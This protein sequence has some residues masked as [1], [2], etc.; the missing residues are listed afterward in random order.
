MPSC[1]LC[2]A[3]KKT[4]F[5]LVKSIKYLTHLLSGSFLPSFSLL[6]SPSFIMKFSTIFAVLATVA[7]A[8]T[9]MLNGAVD[10]RHLTN[11]E[12]LARRQ[13]PNSP[14]HLWEPTKSS[15]MWIFYSR[16]SAVL[17]IVFRSGSPQGKPSGSPNKSQSCN[18]GSVQCCEILATR[19]YRKNLC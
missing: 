18:T 1:G 2:K 15:G 19:S 17:I 10:A 5:T 16:I 13:G 3:Y 9:A 14:K 11:G 4:G 7:T 12:R 8:V 6:P